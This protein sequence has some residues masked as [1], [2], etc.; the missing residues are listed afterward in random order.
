[1][2]I[3][4]RNKRPKGTADGDLEIPKADRPHLLSYYFT[5]M[6]SA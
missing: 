4:E 2:K 6:A 1:V 3:M 5:G